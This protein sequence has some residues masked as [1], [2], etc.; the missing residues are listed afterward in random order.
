METIV[1]RATEDDIYDLI[2]L[3]YEAY[4]PIRALGINFQSANPT[5]ASIRKN[6]EENICFILESDD[7]IVSTLS[8]RMPWSDNPGPYYFPHIWWFATSPKYKNKKFGSKL[9]NY[10]ENDYLLNHLNVPAVSLGTA[11]HHPWL[12]DMYVKKGYQKFGKQDLKKG[13]ITQYLVKVLNQDKF[14][15]TEELKEKFNQVIF[16]EG[17]TIEI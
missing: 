4:E 14:K 9:L 17:E 1:R 10:V 3:M 2:N 7:E 5:E 11:D 8:L 13:H 16:E 6:L 15:G 12:I